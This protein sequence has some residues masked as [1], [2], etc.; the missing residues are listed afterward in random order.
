MPTLCVAFALYILYK[1]NPQQCLDIE[2][3][4][5][6][7]CHLVLIHLPLL[8]MSYFQSQHEISIEHTAW[9]IETTGELVENFIRSGSRDES[10]STPLRQA[11]AAAYASRLTNCVRSLIGMNTLHAGFSHPCPSPCRKNQASHRE[12]WRR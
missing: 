3:S 5:R 10:E 12:G 1:V 4:T 9:P 2:Q 6:L 11:H 7:H 8:H